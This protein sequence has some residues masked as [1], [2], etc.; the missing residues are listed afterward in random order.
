MR[1]SLRNSIAASLLLLPLIA[2][3]DDGQPRYVSGTGQDIGDCVNKFRPCRSLSYA[4]SKAGKGDVISV[5]EGRYE[6]STVQELNDLLTVQGRINAGFDRYT[7]FSDR[8]ATDRTLLVGVPPE[9]RERFEQAG[10]TVIT[11]TKSF[12]ETEAERNERERKRGLATKVRATEQS[13]KAAPCSGNQASGFPCQNVSLHAHLSLGQLKP[14]SPRGNDVWGFFDLNTGRE[15]ALMGLQNGVAI[16]DVTDPAAPEQVAFAEGTATTWRDIKVYQR[17]DAAAKRWRAY[18]YATADAV[19]DFLMVLDLS[20]LPNSVEQVDFSSEFRAAH[21]AYLLNADYTFGLA[22]RDDVP[23]LGVS[24]SNIGTP[25]GSHRLYSLENPR[26][27]QLTSASTK[28]YSHDLAS[29]AVADARKAQCANAATASACEVLTDFNENTLDVWDVTDPASPVLLN[30]PPLSYANLGY[31]HSGWW[32]ED[33]RY[34]YL[35]DELDEQKLGLFTT[36]RVFDMADLRNPQLAGTWTGPTHAIDHNGFVKGNRYYISNYGEGLTVLDITNPTAPQRI[37]YFDT[38]PTGSP[39]T[40]VGAWGVYPF[41]ASGTIAVGDIN[42]GLYLLKN[43][44]LESPNGTFAFATR[45]VTGSE[46]QQVELTITRTGGATGPVSVDIDVL[47]GTAT[48]NDATLGSTRVTWAADDAQPKTVTVSLTGDAETEDMELLFARLKN[49]QGGATI[50]YP[51]TAHIY[52]TEPGATNALRLV[53]SQHRVNQVRGKAL[54]TVARTG[55][56]AGGAQVNY[57]TL[58]VGSYSGFTATEGTLTWADGEADPKIIQ[59]NL[60]PSTLSVGQEGTFQVELY[61]ATNAALESGA[62][63]PASSVT[64]SINVFASAATQP[65]PPPPTP[66]GVSKPKGGGAMSAGWLLMLLCL[67]G[68]AA[69]TSRRRC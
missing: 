25:R 67:A 37:G 9:L 33:G 46:G 51:D 7:G 8:T 10:F 39:T 45:T 47:Y 43:E 38:Y 56:L 44:T 41:F 23:R 57:R 19:E 18:A 1:T 30:D 31:T 60:N 64:A 12:F 34:L 22:V 21:N 48:A 26:A 50:S 20:G 36:V 28:G 4:I 55:S 2:W 54:V 69:I 53:D 68:F 6:V 63:A 40:F 29:Y 14:S 27:P 24:G 11:D 15:Y 65:A 58:P 5:A 17:Y 59:V 62:G 52:V 16:V 13:H 49:P 66:P 3:A 42:S 35:H 61:G 32:S